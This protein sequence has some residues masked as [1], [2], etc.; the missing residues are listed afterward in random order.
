[1][2]AKKILVVEDDL[3]VSLALSARLRSA[4]YDVMAAPGPHVGENI[5]LQERPDLIITDIMLPTMDGLTFVRK[6]KEDGLGGVPFMVITASHEDGLW[7][8][9]M[10]LGATGY[11]E[12]PYD[13]ARLLVAVGE[14]LNPAGSSNSERIGV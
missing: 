10:E 2:S 8:S 11:F 12:K 4:G 6:L 3:Q 9:A 1:M 14:I 13:G 5:A 7:E